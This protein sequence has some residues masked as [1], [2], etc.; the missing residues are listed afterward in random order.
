MYRDFHLSVLDVIIVIGLFMLH[1]LVSKPS[2]CL[3]I[4]LLKSG[5]G[6]D[7]SSLYALHKLISYFAYTLTTIIALEAV[8]IDL[9]VI[10]G[11]IGRIACWP[12]FRCANKSLMTLLP[13]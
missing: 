3:S 11:R 8:G 13:E 4:E 2:S 9:T 5:N 6:S 7:R 12:W 1:G 10:I